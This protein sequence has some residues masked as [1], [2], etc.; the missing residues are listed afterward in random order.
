MILAA[1]PSPY[2][3]AHRLRSGTFAQNLSASQLAE[4]E[5]RFGVPMIELYGMTETAAPVTMGPLY[6]DR[7]PHSIGRPLPCASL[8]IVDA[9]GA[10]GAETGT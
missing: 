7:R 9:D 4:F 5:Q 1:D 6:E 8:R 2:D 3:R 10:D